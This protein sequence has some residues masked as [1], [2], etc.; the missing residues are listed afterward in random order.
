[1]SASSP[2]TEDEL[3]VVKRN[4]L[5]AVGSATNHLATLYR[6]IYLI[7]PENIGEPVHPAVDDIFGKRIVPSIAYRLE[8]R[9]PMNHDMGLV[10]KP[11]NIGRVLEELHINLRRMFS[12]MEINGEELPP[13]EAKDVFASD[14]FKAA[15][16][17]YQDNIVHNKMQTTPRFTTEDE[18]V[19]INNAMQKAVGAFSPEVIP[20]FELT[21]AERTHPEHKITVRVPNQMIK[22][23]VS[24]SIVDRGG[25]PVPLAGVVWALLYAKRAALGSQY[26]PLLPLLFGS[27]EDLI[28]HAE[29]LGQAIKPLLPAGKSI[30]DYY[31]IDG[32][33]MGQAI[34]E[35]AH[36]LRMA[37]MIC[38]YI[39]VKPEFV[40]KTLA[41]MGEDKKPLSLKTPFAARDTAALVCVIAQYIK[42]NLKDWSDAIQ[43]EPPSRVKD[44]EGKRYR[45]LVSA[46]G[47]YAVSAELMDKGLHKL[48]D[49]LYAIEVGAD[50]SAW[51]K[52][53]QALQSSP[54]LLPALRDASRRLN[55]ISK[56]LPGDSQNAAK[57]RAGMDLLQKEIAPDLFKK[58]KEWRIASAVSSPGGHKGK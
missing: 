51:N 28:N 35:E 29:Y 17:I 40:D 27:Q 23:D 18:Q 11:H 14:E 22:V 15:V 8:T 41:L 13:A 33:K 12:M 49:K 57:L 55:A 16:K 2:S 26:G 1:M 9:G 21:L 3:D 38:E 30:H 39:D 54:D 24:E 36:H 34:R 44:V 6:N 50:D 42:K 7:H 53:T 45:E 5:K 58:P 25:S 32:V 31:N 37:R 19:Q 43:A 52:V 10:G 56:L 4:S 48:A 46:G 20:S 47:N